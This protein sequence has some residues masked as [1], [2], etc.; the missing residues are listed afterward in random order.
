MKQ[1]FYGLGLI[2]ILCSFSNVFGQ[3]VSQVNNMRSDTLDVLSYQIK[4]DFTAASSSQISASCKINFKSKMDG[5]DGISLDLLRLTIDSVQ[6]AGTDL[7]YS[8]NDTLLRVDFGQLINTGELD[9]VSIYYHGS[10]Q[11]DPSGFGGFYFHGSY[12][13][14]IGV[15][16]DSNPHNYG[17]VWHPCFDN[18]VERA[19]YD[20]E[21]RSQEGMTSF[22]NGYIL[23]D[24]LTPNNENIRRWIMEDE[25]PSYLACVGVAPY[26]EVN[27][28]YTSSLTGN[29]I[30]VVLAALPQ[31]TTKLK[32]SFIHLFDA[33]DSYEA[34]YG[35]YRWNK[36]G[37]TIVPFSGGAME[38]STCIMYPTFAVNGNLEYEKMMAHELSHQW[39]G[40]LV[41]CKTAE[42]MWINE[43]TAAYSESLFLEHLYGY[44][45]YLKNLKK[46]HRKI[47][48]TAHFNDGGFLP[49]SGV[50]HDATYGT[51]TYDKGATMM[52]NLR[53]YMG[54]TAFFSG[55]KA[56][57]DHFSFKDIDAAGF[58]DALTTYTSFNADHFFENYIFNPGFDGFEVDSFEVEPQGEQYNVKVYVQQKLFEAPN[59]FEDVP[60]Q[61]TFVDADWS[62]T[63]VVELFSGEHSSFTVSLPFNPVMVYLNKDDQLLNAVTGV[64]LTVIAPGFQQLDYAYILLN[65]LA[66]EDSSFLRVEHYRVAPDSIQDPVLRDQI[67]ISPDRYWKVDGIVSNSFESNARIEFNSKNTGAG[68]LDNG[69]MVDHNGITFNEKRIVLLWRP[70]QKVDWKEYEYYDLMDLGNKT[71]GYG[72]IN[73]TKLL[74]GEYAFGFSLSPLNTDEEI[75]LN[76]VHIYPNPTNDSMHIEWSQTGEDKQIEIYDN[77]GKLMKS[78]QVKGNEFTLSVKDFPQ[79]MYQ[80]V[81]FNDHNL[82]GNRKFIKN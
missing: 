71:D 72:F 7:N 78:A 56:I 60:V 18:F 45:S 42:D 15:G 26:T 58:R 25:I 8:Y 27:Q 21:V 62:S 40:D 37:F 20:I 68:N 11:K 74:L 23:S 33:M 79:G 22:S 1:I 81:F 34:S 31:D 2:G 17:R 49:L 59:L 41:T 29:Q 4:M 57:L 70:N 24:S 12:T 14:N 76:Q 6:T 16:F 80:I 75:L 51:H 69:L 38:H 53:T 44:D 39:W 3:N 82:V 73:L 47:L 54:D 48:Q 77:N 32:N 67:V 55:L 19:R 10:P 43:G 35:P 66:E 5:V 63:S 65:I 28:V 50:P 52:H 64:D 46:T 30:P 9:S 13:F 61:V 36:V